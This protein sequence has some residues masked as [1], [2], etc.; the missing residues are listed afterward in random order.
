MIFAFLHEAILA[1]GMASGRPLELKK[2]SF[3]FLMFYM[4]PFRLQGWLLGGSGAQKNV[5][6]IVNVLHE[7]IVAAGRASG[8][9]L[10]LN[11]NVILICVFLHEAVLAARRASGRLLDLKNHTFDFKFSA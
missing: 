2:T 7:A 11:K 5:L 4:T 9:P 8:R 1:A 3:L 10:E 6:L